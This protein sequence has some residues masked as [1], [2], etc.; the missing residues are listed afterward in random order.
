MMKLRM[1]IFSCATGQRD[2]YRRAKPFFEVSFGHDVKARNNMTEPL[3]ALLVRRLFFFLLLGILVSV[4]LRCAAGVRENSSAQWERLQRKRA[5]P[6]LLFI[7]SPTYGPNLWD[8]RRGGGSDTCA[9]MEPSV[10]KFFFFFL[11]PIGWMRWWEA[12]RGVLCKR[13]IKATRGGEGVGGMEVEE[14]GS[15][16][17]DLGGVTHLPLMRANA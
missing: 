5:A 3:T 16:R 15:R 4:A 1:Y 17:E 11:L 14:V 12:A 13:S 8:C 10:R 7:P 6:E 2:S 9:C